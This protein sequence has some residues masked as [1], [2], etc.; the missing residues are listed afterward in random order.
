MVAILRAHFLHK[1]WKPVLCS[2]LP[3]L[4]RWQPCLVPR[5]LLVVL[6]GPL[7][8]ARFFEA[9]L[10][11]EDSEGESSEGDNSGQDDAEEEDDEEVDPEDDEDEE[12]EEVVDEECHIRRGKSNTCPALKKLD[13]K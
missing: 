11:E 2:R 5:C 13:M 1:P 9:Q 3:V 7:D 8:D 4:H 6:Q 10:K 12:E